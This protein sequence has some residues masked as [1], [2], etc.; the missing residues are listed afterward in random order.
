L[1]ESFHALLWRRAPK[2]RHCGKLRL[3]VAL[4]FAVNIWNNGYKGGILGIMNCLGLEYDEELVAAVEDD[5]VRRIKVATK[6]K[7]VEFRRQR[8]ARKAQR[9][10]QAALAKKKGAPDYCPGKF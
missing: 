9:A 6:K 10:A 7:D 4:D 8:K 3:Q 1:N 2:S 5:D